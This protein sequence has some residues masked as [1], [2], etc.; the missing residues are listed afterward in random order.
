MA[1]LVLSIAGCKRDA[2]DKKAVNKQ[3][4]ESPAPSMNYKATPQEIEAARKAWLNSIVRQKD[5]YARGG[6]GVHVSESIVINEAVSNTC[7]NYD[8]TFTIWS[9]DEVGSG[10]E[11]TPVS[12]T[13]VDYNSSALSA[14]LVRSGATLVDPDCKAWEYDGYCDMI[15]EYVYTVANVP[16]PSNNPA[17][18]GSFNLQLLSGFNSGCTPLSA[19]GSLPGTLNSPAYYSGNPARMTVPPTGTGGFFV[20]TDCSTLCYKPFLCPNFGTLQ[21]WPVNNTSNITTVTISTVGQSVTIAPGNYGFSATLTYTIS[22]NTVV[23]G[24]RTGTFTIN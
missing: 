3:Q 16:Y 20:G 7:G 17:S 8:L 1:L 11:E 24:T 10:Y 21:Y 9:Y 6:C 15:R 23:S 12:A 4:P 2:L 13:F 14:T 19:A 5:G 18:V 22:G